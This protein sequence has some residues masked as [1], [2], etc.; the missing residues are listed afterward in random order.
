MRNRNVQ[1]ESKPGRSAPLSRGLFRVSLVA[2]GAA[3]VAVAL[4]AGC[5]SEV[6]RLIQPAVAGSLTILFSS[7]NQ[8]V[9]VSCGCTS[10]PTGGL[11]KRQ[12]IIDK[13]RRVRTDVLLV[14]AGN[15][16]PDHPNALKVKYLAM[17]LEHAKYDAMGLGDQEFDLG[18]PKLQSLASEYKLPFLCANVRDAAGNTVVPPHVVR[19]VA[20]RRVGIFA[21]I[22]DQAPPDGWLWNNH[23]IECPITRAAGRAFLRVSA[24]WFVTRAE[25]DKLVRAMRVWMNR[26]KG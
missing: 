9:L 1:A 15:M 19:Q 5:E 11:A 12:T 16:F 10:V 24:A 2:L 8:G 23:R 17:I 4:V 25:I 6:E 7:D 3:A 22:S 18:V 20:G 26:E 13:Y 21:V 14:D